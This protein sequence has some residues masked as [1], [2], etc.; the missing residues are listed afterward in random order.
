MTPESEEELLDQLNAE[1]SDAY[2]ELYGIRPRWIEFNKVE[3]ADDALA[4]LHDDMQRK[5]EIETQE[6]EAWQHQRQKEEEIQE[7][8]PGI[9][10]RE[11]LPKFAGMGRQVETRIRLRSRLRKIIREVVAS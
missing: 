6:R 5:I 10:D 2:K 8:Q 3:D 1:Y 9:Y 7:L 4:E 11:H